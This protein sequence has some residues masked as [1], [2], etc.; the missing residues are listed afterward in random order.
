MK[1]RPSVLRKSGFGIT[2]KHVDSLGFSP[3]SLGQCCPQHCPPPERM[4]TPL[5]LQEVARLIGVSTWTVRNTLIPQGLPYFQCGG[6]KLL[7][8]TNQITRWIENQQK[9]GM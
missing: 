3:P 4:G 6:G 7:F 8:Y 9:G 2:Q 5:T 1:R